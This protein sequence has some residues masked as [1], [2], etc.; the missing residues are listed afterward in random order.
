MLSTK[1]YSLG[2][3]GIYLNVVGREREGSVMPGPEYDDVRRR[4]KEGL[5]G[6]VDPLTGVHPVTHVWTRDEIYSGYDANL[7]PDLRLGNNLNYRISWQA[8]LGGVP[9]DVFED[10]HKAWSGD[11]CSS[12]PD[13][14]RGILFSNRKLSRSDPSMV[15]IAPTV[16]KVLGVPV[17]ADMDGKPLF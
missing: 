17:P 6:L 16:L 15:D 10:N 5:E 14:V 3:G 2:F 12:D 11:H 1:A 8:S 9:P 4:I 7:I 13:L